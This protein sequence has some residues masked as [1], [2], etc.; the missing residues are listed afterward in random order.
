[1][2]QHRPQGKSVN[3]SRSESLMSRVNITKEMWSCMFVPVPLWANT[4]PVSVRTASP[5]VSPGPSLTLICAV[6]WP[7]TCL[8]LRPRRRQAAAPPP[9]RHHNIKAIVLLHFLGPRSSR[10]RCANN[11]EEEDSARNRLTHALLHANLGS[12]YRVIQ[13]GWMKNASVTQTCAPGSKWINLKVVHWIKWYSTR[14]HSSL[15][16]HMPIVAVCSMWIR[17]QVWKSHHCFCKNVVS[18]EGNTLGAC[19]SFDTVKPQKPSVCEWCC[20]VSPFI[21][22]D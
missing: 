16:D 15:H 10:R 20:S 14:P 19:E 6:S 7:C 5:C 8:G 22:V 18:A 4:L 17:L 13:F 2:N 1:M 11:K 21:S 12:Q 3:I 9:C